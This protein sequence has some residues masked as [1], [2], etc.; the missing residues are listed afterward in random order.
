MGIMSNPTIGETIICQLAGNFGRLVAMVGATHFSFHKDGVSFRFKAPATNK[1]N[2]LRITL[3]P[4]DTYKVEFL[5][6]RGGVNAGVTTISEVSDMYA[7]D[8]KGYFERETG[9]YLSL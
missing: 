8:L 7:E 6:V 4:S 1:A 9:L 2:C 3:E 5:R